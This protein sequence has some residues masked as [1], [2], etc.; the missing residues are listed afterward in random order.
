MQ[1]KE[2]DIAR[3]LACFSCVSFLLLV[4]FDVNALAE[5][6]SD[7]SKGDLSKQYECLACRMIYSRNDAK[8]RQYLGRPEIDV[9]SSTACDGSGFL[10]A[11]MLYGNVSAFS[12]LA[13]QILKAIKEA[14]PHADKMSPEQ[15][16]Q[17][18]LDAVRSY[19][20]PVVLALPAPTKD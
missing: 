4:I 3:L 16:L 11:S 1:R 18:V 15:V 8:L 19:E 12:I 5:P 10:R 14:I 13:F 9:N 7:C 6:Y 17:H 20:S 2:N